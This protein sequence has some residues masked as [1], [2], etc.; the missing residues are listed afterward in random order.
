[1][2]CKGGKSPPIKRYKNKGGKS[3]SIYH[4]TDLNAV[5]LIL[6]TKKLRLTDSRYLNDIKELSDGLTFIYEAIENGNWSETSREQ[7]KRAIDFIKAEINEYLLYGT[8]EEPIFVCSF[9]TKPDLL[10]QWRSYGMFAIEFEE[11]DLESDGF[12]LRKCL[13]NKEEKR[14]RANLAVKEAILGLE[15][16]F[17]TND[18]QFFG[19]AF[20]FVPKLVEL[21]S[22][23]K[24]SGF[25]E[26]SEV[27]H[28]DVVG[29]TEPKLKFRVKDNILVPY[30]DKEIFL[31]SIKAIHV[32]PV[33][34][35]KMVINSL[36]QYIR[37]IWSQHEREWG[38]SE[39]HI[40][41]VESVIPYRG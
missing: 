9:S 10:S 3:V 27:R 40:D 2:E 19:D 31:P 25:S 1:M 22:I 21:A 15:S 34:D 17:H 38:W 12:N 28:I 8:E 35:R 20:D 11:L 39:H 14:D 24:D 18:G 4:Y 30:I 16:F 29:E 13:Y 32:G 36:E 41:I 5:K 23:F 7:R 37:F 26:E 6:E 33:P